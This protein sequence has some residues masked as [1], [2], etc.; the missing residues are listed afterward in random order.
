MDDIVQAVDTT[1]YVPTLLED[2][3]N[4]LFS[5]FLP[6]ARINYCRAPSPGVLLFS[7]MTPAV[8]ACGS[9]WDDGAG[10]GGDDGAAFGLGG[11]PRGCNPMKSRTVLFLMAC[12]WLNWNRE[13]GIQYM[14]TP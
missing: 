8:I 5:H 2:L 11:T 6:N 9:A 13:E 7:G 12:V 14:N 4:V 1:I 10:A 3:S